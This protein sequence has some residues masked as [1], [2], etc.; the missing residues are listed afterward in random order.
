[1]NILQLVP[2]LE[3]G[4]VERGTVDFAK[5]LTLHGHKAI[6]VSGGGVMVRH[7]DDVGARHYTLPVYQKNPFTAIAAI[8]RLVRIIENE[9]IDIV[10]ARSRVPGWIG[11]IAAKL[12]RRV[13][14]TTAHGY[15]GRHLFSRVMSWGRFVIVASRDM[16][17]HMVEDFGTPRNRVR[18]I[19]RGV[20]LSEFKF[21]PPLAQPKSGPE[22]GKV[23][24]GVIARITPLKGHLSF[25]KAVSIMH[26][27][28]S[29][30][31]VMIVGEAPKSKKRYKEEVETLIRR[32]GL[33]GVITM[34][35]ARSDIPRI[36]SKLDMVVLPTVTPEAFGRVIVEA[37]ASGVPV[38]ATSVGG[39]V[40]IIR[41]GENGLLVPPGD[42]RALAEAMTRI[43]R[44]RDLAAQMVNTARRDVQEMFSLNTMA[45]DTLKVYGEA[46]K[47]KSILVIKLSA[48]GDVI[49]AL[50]CLY[51]LRDRFP[52]AHIG[53]VVE[54][55]AAPLLR[56]IEAL[57]RIHC[58]HRGR[59]KTLRTHLEGLPLFPLL[60][61]Y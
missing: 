37:Q 36:L 2:K 33:S 12:T 43:A 24:I 50:P 10:H 53:W 54:E 61:S 14:I 13:F 41:D 59:H 4:G 19:P 55:F 47:Q 16:A 46:L 49:H 56:N 5:Y 51:A 9:N 35:G 38:V 39:I 17:K 22:A 27:D 58:L 7:L 57:D 60:T 3:M 42:P 8:P 30:L 25:I 40:D 21:S 31:R 15:Y 28:F 23:T 11:Y 6:V 45:K 48:I 20:D 34:A 44:D 26:R 32:L 52:Q 18:M 29:G 1:M